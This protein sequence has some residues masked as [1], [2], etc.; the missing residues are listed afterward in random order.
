MQILSSKTRELPQA[1]NYRL[2]L[3]GGLKALSSPI[4][5]ETLR[6]CAKWVKAHPKSHNRTGL[7][8]P[9]FPFICQHQQRGAISSTAQHLENP[10]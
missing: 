5:Q 9:P 10:R 4:W 7:L 8:L 1:T 3:G 6:C 2:T